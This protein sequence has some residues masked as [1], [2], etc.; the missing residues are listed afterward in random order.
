MSAKLLSV[1]GLRITAGNG[2][3]VA[4]DGIAFDV[5]AG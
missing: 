5:A 3:V 4:V 1:Q 2:R